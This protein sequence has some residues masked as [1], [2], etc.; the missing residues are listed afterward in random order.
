[1]N[2]V[3]TGGTLVDPARRTVEAADLPVS[4]GR[5]SSAGEGTRS[6]DVSG[7][8]V[9]PGLVCAHHHLYSA[10]ARGMPGPEKPPE[11]FIEILERVWWRLDRALDIDTVHLSAALGAVGA[12]RSGT[13]AIVDHHAS[14]G[15]IDGSLDA[16]A[17]GVDA[18]G[19]RSVVCYEVTDRHG[20]EGGRA[21]I[22]E[23]VRFLEANNRPLTRGMMGAHA[24]FTIGPENLESLV[25]AARERGVP[26]H[27][28]LAE[29][30]YDE[31]DSLERYGV[32]TAH[33]LAKAGAL[34]EGDMLA[35]GVHLD[36][37][38]VE[39]VRSSGAWVAHNPRS[40]MNN[41]VGYAPVADLGE[42]VVLGTDGIDGDMFAEA[43]SCYL[44]A[45]EASSSVG[46]DFAVGR[47]GAG[48]SFVGSMFGEPAL[49]T[50]EAGAPADIIV[51]DSNVPTPLTVSNVAGH[52]IFGFGAGHVRDVMVGGSWV[53]RDRQHQLIDEAELAARCREAAPKL[54]AR[55]EEL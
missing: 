1:M 54:W 44:K 2:A 15:A 37:E 29:D 18:A 39:T 38:E 20:K 9:M 30:D 24:S 21:G 53:V 51:L 48:A 42:R 16:L 17:D 19:V 22:D 14:P 46:P 43:R 35:H 7:C 12:A 50:L 10:M 8:I 36:I 5:I 32:R 47:L 6:F 45:R 55:M 52:M 26:V 4:S 33:R 3:L 28:H 13:T 41:R 11:S 31:R 25:G 23:N 40:N 27:I 34:E 49:G